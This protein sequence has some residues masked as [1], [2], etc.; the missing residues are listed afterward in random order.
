MKHGTGAAHRLQSRLPWPKSTL[1]EHQR[2]FS[3]S[4]PAPR[5]ASRR[6]NQPHRHGVV[7]A[8][9]GA[10][11]TFGIGATDRY[12][13]AWPQVFYNDVLPTSTVMYNFGIPG[14]TTA[15]ALKEEVPAAVGVHPTVVTVWLNVN[16]LIQGVTSTAFEAQFREVVHTLRRGGQT[17]V[18]VANTPDLTQLPAYKACLTSA[19]SAGTTCLI[20]SS[21][22]PSPAVVNAISAYNTVIARVAKQDGATLVDLYT[23][24][25]VIAQHPDW[26]SSDGFHPNGQGY[27]AIAHA[28]EDA[29]RRG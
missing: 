12:R 11:E 29:Y 17:R 22:M 2:C 15:Q 5:S 25:A 14:A 20:P 21:L 4:P 16:D 6:P 10:S 18:L 13:E 27:A 24:D 23:K 26:F 7:Y 9:V 28:F 1:Q 3:F 8:A 19:A